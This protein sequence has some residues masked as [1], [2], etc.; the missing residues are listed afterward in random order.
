MFYSQ[1]CN[2]EARKLALLNN[3]KSE[4]IVELD[5]HIKNYQQQ[6]LGKD[7]QVVDLAVFSALVLTCTYSF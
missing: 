2:W 4:V 7:Q 5:A 1:T 3:D 6:K